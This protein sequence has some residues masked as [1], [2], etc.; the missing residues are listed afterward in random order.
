MGEMLARVYGAAFANEVEQKLRAFSARSRPGRLS[1]ANAVVR[2]R[3]H[4]RLQGSG[5]EAMLTKK[6]SSMPSFV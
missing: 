4:Q 2:A 6:S 3:M 5:Y 1:L